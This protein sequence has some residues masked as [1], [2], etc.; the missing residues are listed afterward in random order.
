MLVLA[1]LSVE[2]AFG[3]HILLGASPRSEFFGTDPFYSGFL[4][5]CIMA[6]F[7]VFLSQLSRK[8]MQTAESAL[9]AALFFS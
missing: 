6:L 5:P 9:F 3:A 1:W 4:L 2:A 8:S 7:L